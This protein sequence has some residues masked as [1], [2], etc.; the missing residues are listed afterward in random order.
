MQNQISMSDILSEYG[1]RYISQNHIKGQ[2]KGIIR[3]LASCRSIAMGSHYEKCDQC[4]YLGKAYNSCRNRHCTVCQQKDKEQWLTKRME[5]LLP[6]GYYHLVFTIPV[7]LND[8]CLQN[9]KIMYNILFKAAS[10]TILELAR[11][12]KHMGA[13]TGLITVLHT[14]GQNLMEH[15]HLHCIMPAGG[16]SSDKSHW[17]HI[18]KK[19][20]FFVYYKVLS[21]LFRNKFLELMGHA[22]EKGNLVFR[23]KCAWLN[24][25]KN[26]RSF[27]NSLS[28]KEWVVNIQPPFGCA[29]K[30]LEYLSR[31]VFRIAITN[32]RIIEVKDDKVLFSW[33]DYRTG[34][35]RKMKL[36]VNEFIRR[37][38]LHVLPPGFFKIRYYGIFSSRFRKEN[39]QK[40]KK[41]LK[42]EKLIQK[43]E[44][45]QDG[46][47]TFE[48]PKTPWNE[49]L[50]W[51]ENYKKPNCPKC[52]K[53]NLRFAGIVP[54]EKAPPG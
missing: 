15:P 32:R 6:I 22:C 37:F 24:T 40:S 43:Q 47:Q 39:I 50:N 36:D 46:I 38:L 14:W 27:I 1:E 5:E 25:A 2:E 17:V 29:E 8:L 10:E 45:M 9:K 34:R 44:D 41:L 18:Q 53:G 33:K 13:D 42:D 3:L 49:I 35:F 16:L 11:D 4:S 30:V 54:V 7:Q 52:K 23:G 51:I 21:R 48:K 31:Y 19:N 26:F 28:Q 12:T 20:D